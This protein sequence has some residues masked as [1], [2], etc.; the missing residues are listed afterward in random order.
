MTVPRGPWI[1]L[2]SVMMAFS[3][4]THL[5][6]LARKVHVTVLQIQDLLNVQNVSNSKLRCLET[7]MLKC[8]RPH[9]LSQ[10][11]IA[12]IDHP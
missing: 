9:Q 3:G 2:R 7:C 10:C 6:V 8:S 4:H 12:N 1:G 5:F 11:L